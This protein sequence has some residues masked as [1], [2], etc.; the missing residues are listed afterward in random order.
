MYSENLKSKIE[1]LNLEISILAMK[2]E[3]NKKIET[4]LFSPESFVFYGVCIGLL[5][6]ILQSLN[7]I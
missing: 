4:A 3:Q 5:C 2:I 7:L 1:T 6:A